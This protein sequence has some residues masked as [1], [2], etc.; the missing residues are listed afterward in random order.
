MMEYQPHGSHREVSVVETTQYS[1]LWEQNIG[2]ASGPEV[3]PVR[4]S[5]SGGGSL[6][7]LSLSNVSKGSPSSLLERWYACPQ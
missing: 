5:F 6:L 4:P 3:L 7:A 1:T 2:A